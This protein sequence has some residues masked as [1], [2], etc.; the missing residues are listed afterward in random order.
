MLTRFYVTRS[1]L[2]NVECKLTPEN[3]LTELTA[4]YTKLLRQ[5]SERANVVNL[6]PSINTLTRLNMHFSWNEA[7]DAMMITFYKSTR[8]LEDHNQQELSAA[9]AKQL[10]MQTECVRSA[11]HDKASFLNRILGFFSICFPL[12]FIFGSRC[13]F[14][15]RELSMG[16]VSLRRDLFSTLEKEL[17]K[18]FALFFCWRCWMMIA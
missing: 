12:N 9:V 5:R 8:S 10:R 18:Q 15:W 11:R 2:C 16:K 6:Q 4:N 1:N 7:G 3:N 13:R 17:S 14:E